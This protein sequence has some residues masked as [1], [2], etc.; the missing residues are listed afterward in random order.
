MWTKLIEPNDRTRKKMITYPQELYKFLET[1]GIEVANLVFVS[2]DVVCPSGRYI[3][4]KVP[5]VR[6]TNDVIGAYVTDGA[7]IH[8]YCYIDKLQQRALYCD[9]DSVIYIQPNVEPPLVETGDCLGAVTSELRPG[10][11]IEEFVSGGPKKYAYRIVNLVT[12]NR[13]TV[14]KVR[15][16]MLNYS[17]SHVS[18]DVMK[19]LILRGDFPETV[20]VH[21]EHNIKRKRADG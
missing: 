8:L 15:G 5:N 17:A 19:A 3:A 2:D 13:E 7:R 10:F 6:H 20:T 4:E 21:T 12:S 9:T 11:H 1:L 18:F 16:I 14:Y